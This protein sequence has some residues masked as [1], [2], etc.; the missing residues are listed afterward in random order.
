MDPVECIEYYKKRYGEA[1]ER[2]KIL[3][4]QVDEIFSLLDQNTRSYILARL[5]SKTS[6]N[7]DAHPE[8]HNR[9]WYAENDPQSLVD[10]I[11]ET[12]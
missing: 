12:K 4:E 3:L 11:R 9:E 1:L 5:N 10:S 8:P 2:E 7:G 6:L